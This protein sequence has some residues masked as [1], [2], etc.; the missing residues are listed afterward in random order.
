MNTCCVKV[1]IVGR[2]NVGKSTLLNALVGHKVSIVG[3]KPQTTRQQIT[4]VKTSEKT[5]IVYVDTPGVDQ[6]LKKNRMHGFMF[7]AAISTLQWVDMAVFLVNRCEWTDEEDRWLR[8]LKKSEVP[9]IFAVNK[10]DTLK[11]K[12]KLLPYLQEI[13]KKHSF[14]DIV[15]LSALKGTNVVDLEKIIIKNA[16]EGEHLFE[17]EIITDRS[18]KFLTGEFI[19]EQIINSL[20]AELPYVTAVEIEVFEEKPNSYHI[21]A[22]I[23]VEKLGQKKIVIGDEGKRLKFIG[24]QARLEIEKLLDKKVFLKLWV[25]VKSGWTD[26]E[27]MLKELG[28]E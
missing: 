7:R 18:P 28:L 4:G 26:D 24:T 14:L 19:R 20:G 16:P 15:P 8:L 13:S 11:E 23:F 25:K 6:A 3:P 12:A 27:R 2:P 9:I 10:V 21:S 1:A 5:Q 17:E 22:V